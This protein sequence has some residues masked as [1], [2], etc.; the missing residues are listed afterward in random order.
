MCQSPMAAG[1]MACVARIER[2][3]GF[4]VFAKTGEAGGSR[5]PRT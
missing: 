2:A 4:V 1:S 5:L 3:R